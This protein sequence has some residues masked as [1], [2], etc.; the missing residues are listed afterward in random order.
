M[1][2]ITKQRAHAQAQREVPV[3]TKE[4]I[5]LA[6]EHGGRYYLPYQLHATKAQFERAYP[7]VGQLRALKRKADPT[8]KLSN[9]LWKKYL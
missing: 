8:G 3:W 4:L 1:F 6:L 9:E 2:C 5:D 7:E